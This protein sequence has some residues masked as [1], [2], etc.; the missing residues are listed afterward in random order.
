MLKKKKLPTG[1]KFP[2]AAN[3]RRLQTCKVSLSSTRGRLPAPEFRP[4]HRRKA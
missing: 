1:R 3:Q 2:Q 4:A